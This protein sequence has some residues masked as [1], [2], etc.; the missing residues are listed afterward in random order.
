MK[1]ITLSDI[2]FLVLMIISLALGV[3]FYGQ[4]LYH[5]ELINLINLKCK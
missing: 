1:N 5:E 2:I 3:G 4:I